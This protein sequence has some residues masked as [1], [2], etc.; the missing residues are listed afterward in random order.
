MKNG[1]KTY[2]AQTW[3]TLWIGLA[4]CTSSVAYAVDSVSANRL[5]NIDFRVNKAQ[6]AVLI[7]ELASASVVVDVQKIPQGLSIDL[8]K[9]DV[10]D[11]KLY[12]LDVKDFATPVQSIEVFRKQ[13]T[14][15]L[16]V[17]IEGEFKHDYSLKGKYLEVVISKL[18]VDEKPKS[19]SILEKEGKLISINF[20]DI[21][22]RNVLQLI[23]DYNSF[24][25]VV[26]DSVVGN[27]TLRLDGVPWQQV[28]DIILQVKGLDKRVDG[29]VILIAPKEELDL[30]EKQALEK[31]RLTEELGDLKSQIIKINFAKASDIAAMIGGEGN[32]NMLSDRGSISI[33]ERTNSLLIRE[34]PDNI[35]VISEI[36]ESLDIPV[37]QVQIEA[38]IVTVK[39]GNID[40]LGV[41]WGVM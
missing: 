40:E 20:Q 30:R 8:L 37:K 25:L 5:E 15:E 34:L 24:N 16:I 31:A 36:I 35:A 33:D 39:E 28:L 2:V 27:L 11:D 38:R 7:V 12:L 32:V 10:A 22:V 14:T 1:L 23:A 17:S 29:N 21:P 3:L 26:S 6:A 19:K 18:K 9:T 41:R 13:P 4:V